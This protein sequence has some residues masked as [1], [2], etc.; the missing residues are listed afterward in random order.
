MFWHGDGTRPNHIGIY[1]GDRQMLVAPRTG[2]V[3][4]YQEIGRT[5]ARIRRVIV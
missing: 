4:K 3:V 2:D 1:A 5:P